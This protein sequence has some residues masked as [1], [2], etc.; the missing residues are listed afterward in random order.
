MKTIQKLVELQEIDAQLLELKALL[1]NLPEKV[2]ELK[3]EEE[4]LT[5]AVETGRNRLKEIEVLV[6]KNELDIQSCKEDIEKHKDQL[7]LVTT[8]RQYDAMM[9]EIEI[10]QNK[11]NDLETQNLELM[12]EK[13]QLDSNVTEQQTNLES[14]SSDLVERRKK[15]EERYSETS[16]QKDE[17]EAAREEK[18]K[19]IDSR[20]LR[21]YNRVLNAREGVAVTPV[22]HSACGGCGAFI[23]RQIIAEIRGN[24]TLHT[25]DVCGRFLYWQRSTD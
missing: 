8:N 1:G 15:L 2:A 20:Y 10:Q 5:Q 18:I 4:R 21:Q 24:T 6:N 3:T 7:S 11:L 16:S 19:E 12:E 14:L 13:E 17:L 25:C 23:P 9:A 22:T